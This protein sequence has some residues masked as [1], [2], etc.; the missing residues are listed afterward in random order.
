MS[1]KHLKHINVCYTHPD[2]FTRPSFS[3]VMKKCNFLLYIKNSLAYNEKI[4]GMILTF[5]HFIIF[6]CYKKSRL[7]HGYSV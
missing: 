6:L 7:Y 1:G 4:N 3:L 5:I 2:P